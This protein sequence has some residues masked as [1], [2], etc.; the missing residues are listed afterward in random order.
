MCESDRNWFEARYIRYNQTLTTPLSA[1]VT[2]PAPPG[3]PLVSTPSQ[4]PR[5]STPA[6]QEG[7]YYK[8]PFYQV[9][10]K[11]EEAQVGWI[12][13]SQWTLPEPCLARSTGR[14]H[15]Q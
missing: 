15:A 8:R 4:M 7:G 3:A 14:S 5:N 2:V 1:F 6:E 9:R 12:S 11:R 13:A 10:L